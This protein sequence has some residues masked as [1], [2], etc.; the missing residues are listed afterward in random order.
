MEALASPE[1]WRLGARTREPLFLGNHWVPPSAISSA[2]AICS[3][4]N[5]PPGRRRPSTAGELASLPLPPQRRVSQHLLDASR[6]TSCHASG[7][8]S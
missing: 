8:T 6:A 4:D 3:H 7:S 5:R 2:E 1:H